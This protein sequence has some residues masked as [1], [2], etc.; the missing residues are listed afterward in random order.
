MQKEL[1]SN[2]PTHLN[3]DRVKNAL[4]KNQEEVKPEDALNLMLDYFNN[5]IWRYAGS[6]KQKHGTS[7]KEI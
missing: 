4:S 5:K 2:G 7:F 6:N 1:W 3:I